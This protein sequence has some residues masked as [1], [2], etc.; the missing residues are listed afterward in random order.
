MKK[1]GNFQ[2]SVTPLQELKNLVGAFVR[3]RDWEQF[4]TPKNLAMSIAIEAAELMEI[5]QW[6]RADE[7]SPEVL[8]SLEEELADVIIYSLAMANRTGI[9]I[10][11]AVK[12]KV[13][14]NEKKYPKEEYCG[15]YR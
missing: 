8:S 5:F 7:V 3:E 10:S 2:D 12:K 11:R 13:E 4:H 14:K 15:K 6:E 1:D 9:D